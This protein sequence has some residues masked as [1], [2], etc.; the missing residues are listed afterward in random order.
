[1]INLSILLQMNVAERIEKTVLVYLWVAFLLV[2][3]VVWWTDFTR[4]FVKG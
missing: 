4:F 2:V 1:M 3:F